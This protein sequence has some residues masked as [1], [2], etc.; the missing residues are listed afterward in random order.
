MI[1]LD[2]EDF[3]LSTH[4]FHLERAERSLMLQKLDKI[5]INTIINMLIHSVIY[6]VSKASER[7]D[8]KNE[9][10]DKLLKYF[11]LFMVLEIYTALLVRKKKKTSFQFASF[12]SEK[13]T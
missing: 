7:E 3:F 6:H 4:S 5:F 13:K 1:E 9:G 10:N 12:F 8:E 11:S 2:H